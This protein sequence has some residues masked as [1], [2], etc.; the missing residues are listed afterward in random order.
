M[1]LSRGLNV[2]SFEIHEKPHHICSAHDLQFQIVEIGDGIGFR[3]ESDV[4]GGKS[5]V[6]QIKYPLLVK[7]DLD[8]TPLCDDVK[9]MPMPD[10]DN[11]IEV[12]E[13]MPDAF[14]DPV[15]ADILLQR[16]GPRQVVVTIIG[17]PPHQATTH[18]G[19]ALDRQE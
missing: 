16:I 18:V 17:G 6:T 9:G 10:I 3:P 11:M 19:F 12:L 5:L 8:P 1:G 4:A 7:E 2:D 15:D 13:H 14:D